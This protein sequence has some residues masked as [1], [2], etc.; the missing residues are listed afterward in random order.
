MED[1][2]V[3]KSSTYHTSWSTIGHVYE[4]KS[5]NKNPNWKNP[6][7]KTKIVRKTFGTDSFG[8]VTSDI[9]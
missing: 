5:E 7:T 8:H 9:L 3:H 1:D 4:K 6:K 2:G